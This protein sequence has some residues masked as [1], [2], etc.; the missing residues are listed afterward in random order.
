MLKREDPRHDQ[1]QP[2]VPNIAL[3]LS[4]QVDYRVARVAGSQKLA[5]NC[6]LA[7]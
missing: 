5:M 3:V 1:L 7:H 6:L 2:H 4:V